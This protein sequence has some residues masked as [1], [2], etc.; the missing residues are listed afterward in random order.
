MSTR[1]GMSAAGAETRPVT[2]LVAA[3][4]GEGGGVLTNWIV[5]AAQASDLPVQATSIPG[6]AQRTGATTYYLEVWP[7]PWG[8]LNGRAPLLALAPAAGEVDV[9]A[10]SE[11]LEAG[12]AVRSGFVTPERTLLIA[13]THRV[14]T[15]AEKMAMD[16]GR[17]DADTLRRAAERRSQARLLLD[18]AQVAAR[19]DAPLN[20]VLLGTLAGCGRLPIAEEAFRE[21]V[22]AEGK[23]AEAN[24]RGFEAGLAAA[25]GHLSAPVAAAEMRSAPGRDVSA[26]LERI[27]RDVPAPAREVL[28]LGVQRLADYQDRAYAALYL[29]RLA[30][31]LAGDAALLAAVARQLAVRMSYEDAIRVAQAKLR[32]GRLARIR[33][34]TGAAPGDVVVITEFLK[35]GLEEIADILPEPLARGLFALARRWPRLGRIR[36]GLHL[37]STTVWGFARLRLLAGLRG[38]RRSTW[39]FRREQEAIVAWLALIARAAPLGTPLAREVAE[40]ARLIKGYGDT[41]R[42]GTDSYARICS[43]LIE[44]A[45]AGALPPDRAAAAIAE[46]RAAALADP[47]GS[48]L[49]DAL[50]RLQGATPGAAPGTAPPRPVARA[51][52]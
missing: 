9:M 1:G 15:T 39:R 47:E 38:W 22:R 46:A 26:L 51:S 8:T 7:H 19:A 36:P 4:G 11:L 31:L 27:E 21:G 2:I 12:R 6:V 17:F 3:L 13:S 18:L 28:T 49:D 42:R 5:N 32:P 10:A 23:A 50:A 33:A 25:R 43:A 29:E 16:D 40:C 24:L 34:E 30:P 14:Y 35:P 45:L 20:A 37:R 52:A 44:P 41:H 48:A